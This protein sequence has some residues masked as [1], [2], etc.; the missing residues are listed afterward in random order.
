MVRGDGQGFSRAV[1]PNIRHRGAVRRHLA[2]DLGDGLIYREAYTTSAAEQ[3]I[4][5]LV[6]A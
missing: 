5:H 1:F 2:A 6:N 3:V 4:E